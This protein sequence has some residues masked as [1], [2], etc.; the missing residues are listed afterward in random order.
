MTEL[1]RADVVIGGDNRELDRALQVAAKQMRRFGGELERAGRQLTLVVAAPIAGIGVAAVRAATELESL[2]RGLEVSAG[3]AQAASEQLAELRE[4]AKL[5]GIGF[6]EAIAGATRLNIAFEH[7]PNTVQRS[8]TALRQFANAVALTGGGRAELDRVIVQLGQIA[9]AGKLLTHDLRPIIQTAPAVATALRQAFGTINAGEIEALGLS[10]QEFFD[11]LIGALGELP[12]AAAASRTAFENFGDAV[13]RAR[14]AVGEELLPVVTRLLN[15]LTQ[16]ATSL[17]SVD[18]TTVAWGAGIAALAVAVPVLT[19]AV[20]ALISAVGTITTLFVGLA[21]VLT[22][23]GIAALLTGGALVTGVVALGA[24]FFAVRNAVKGAADELDRIEQSQLRSFASLSSDELREE[25]ELLERRRE[26]LRTGL[27]QHPG[28]F[29]NIDLLH[30]TSEELRLAKQALEGVAEVSTAK[31][32]PAITTVNAG[33]LNLEG[34]AAAL[35]ANITLVAEGGDEASRVFGAV[36]NLAGVTVDVFDTASR[37]ALVF[38]DAMRQAREIT[39]AMRTP[40]EVFNDAIARLGELPIDEETFARAFEAARRELERATLGMQVFGDAVGD[41]ALQGL[42]A[43]VAFATGASDAIAQFVKS[44][45]ADLARLALRMLFIRGILSALPGVGSFLGFDRFVG[46]F[47][48]GGTIPGGS[49]GIV[50]EVGPEIVSGPATVTP[51]G[52]GITVNVA[53]GRVPSDWWRDADWIR[54]IEQANRELTHRGF[55]P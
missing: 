23:G 10:N 2:T 5:P 54:G 21:A 29:T 38:T 14:A 52:G 8:N 50:G 24:A 4:I 22:G 53:A 19:V 39:L 28:N 43:M 34:S 51:M 55:R 16:M 41:V 1:A 33:L 26:I 11:Q 32:R 7:L 42:D 36:N 9:S 31:V 48:H 35:A 12:R 27:G 44:A 40:L 17:E 25:I 6:R 30:R 47:A 37:S 3:S 46:G 15:T 45:L 18:R 20:G 49:W 13:F